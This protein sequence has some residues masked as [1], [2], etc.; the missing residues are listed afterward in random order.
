MELKEVLHKVVFVKSIGDVVS[1]QVASVAFDSRK[2]KQDTLFVA[3]K[4]V[5]VDGHNYI[6]KAISLGATVVVCQDIPESINENV[7]YV[8]VKSSDKAL[9]QIASNFYQNPSSNLKLV[10]VTGTNGKT[11]IAS[12][13]YQLFTQ[14]GYQTGLLST[15]KVMV[16]NEQFKATHTTPD[17]LSINKYMAMM[18]E[19]GVEYCFMEVS[20]HGIHQSRIHALDFNGGVFTNLSHDHL[21]YHNTFAEYRDV[22][23]SFFDGLSTNA[24]ALSNADDKNGKVMLQ[25]TK[26]TKIMY[27][28]KTLADVKVKIV[29]KSF[30]GMLLSLD[31]NEL[32]VRLVG[33]FNASNLAAIY[34]VAKELGVNDMELLIALS[35]LESV[36][37]RFEYQVSD[38][39]VVSIVDYAH[40]PDALKNILQTINDIAPLES[41]VITVVGCGGNRDKD[42]R[43]KMAKLATQLSSQ[44]VLTS[45]NP[46]DEEPDAI[47]QEMEKGIQISDLSKVLSITDRKQAIKTACKLAKK[48][49]VVLVAG[50][51]HETYQEIKG[52]RIHFSDR[53]I[54]NEVLG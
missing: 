17:S 33:G 1:K 19:S 22:K 29:E 16:G 41:E 34:G 2:V 42:K 4:G 49:D 46:R 45:D 44:V 48:G 23:K 7:S 53:E 21:D 30:S 11:T 20:S 5:T 18:V 3:Q 8:Q 10:G 52:E 32:W 31:N 14:L 6:D 39:G 43:P 50:K 38:K 27:A 24:F 54:L 40:T 13:L 47:I 28:Q 35:K 36:D 9:A 51:G 15:V 12:L 25:N 26:A 37:G